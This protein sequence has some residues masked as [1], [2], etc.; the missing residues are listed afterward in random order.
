MPL[1]PD[2]PAC[3]P[4]GMRA[5]PKWLLWTFM[6]V[7]CAVGMVMV[8]AFDVVIDHTATVRTGTSSVWVYT[9]FV[10]AGD[11]LELSVDTH[12]ELG[13]IEVYGDR[14]LLAEWSGDSESSVALTV[15]LPDRVGSLPLVVHT[16]WAYVGTRGDTHAE[17]LPVPLE[18]RAPWSLWT[19]RLASALAAVGFF[20]SAALG[21]ARVMLW[22]RAIE[23][24]ADE[25]LSEAL[26]GTACVLLVIYAVAGWWAFVLP[27]FAALQWSGS[28]AASLWMGVWVL[29]A[30]YAGWRWLR[31]PLPGVR[32]PG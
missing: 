9:P 16:R 7:A 32:G 24:H 31:R 5:P 30:P 13:R 28:L 25:N 22:V 19:L 8:V 10:G 4:P 14:A 23:R 18:L 26:G 3:D 29:G 20:T 1:D 21:F 17:D 6:T 12:G 15:E 2:G 27:M 11:A